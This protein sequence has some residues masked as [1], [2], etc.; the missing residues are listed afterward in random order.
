[1]SLIINNKISFLFRASI[2]FIF[3]SH[4]IVRVVENTIPEFAGFLASKAIP[5][6]VSVV[7]GITIYEMGGSILLFLGYF[8]K[9]ISIGFIALL[10]VGIFLIHLSNGWF[11]GEH[12]TGGLEYSFLLIIVLIAIV[13]E[14]KN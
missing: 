3:L 4:S 7:W 11:V 10:V 13:L 5:F 14:E 9:W 1:M 12:G 8:V 6:S 2:A